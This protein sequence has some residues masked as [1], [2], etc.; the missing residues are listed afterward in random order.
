MINNSEKFYDRLTFLYPIID[1]FLKPQKHKF[2]SR[3]NSCPYGRLLEIGVGNG[4]HFNYYNTHEIIGID[5]SRSMLA[6]ARKHLKGN[7]RLLHMSGENLLFQNK[8][9]D[10]VILSHVI[11]VVE[12][13][14]KLLEEVYRVLKPNGKV[15]ILNHFTPNNWLKYLDKTFESLSRLFYF[16]SVF[17]ISSLRKLE[18]FKLLEEFN[19]GLF[20]YFKILIYEKSL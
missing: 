8:T 5:T 7:I 10:Y 15:F 17:H 12:D 20:S 6:S 4:T 18:K 13:P 9:F 16:K 14:E 11:A 1:F 19:A 2:F 3:I